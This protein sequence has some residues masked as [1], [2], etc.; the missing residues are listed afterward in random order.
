MNKKDVNAL[1]ILIILVCTGASYLINYVISEE[2]LFIK[3][4]LLYFPYWLTYLLISSIRIYYF[5]ENSHSVYPNLKNSIFKTILVGFIVY[6]TLLIFRLFHDDTLPGNNRSL[7]YSCFFL[8]T[9]VFTPHC[10]AFY[11]TGVFDSFIKSF[12]IVRNAF[13]KFIVFH[14]F[15]SFLLYLAFVLYSYLKVRHLDLLYLY[16]TLFLIVLIVGEEKIF[17]SSIKRLEY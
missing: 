4:Y 9:T 14:F 3:N 5:Y 13:V 16:R 7:V 8:L 11:N 17:S 10:I 15:L 12:K 6:L 1:S 2:N